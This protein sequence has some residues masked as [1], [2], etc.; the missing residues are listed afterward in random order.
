MKK[1]K[2]G[3][4]LIDAGAITALQLNEVLEDQKR[5]GGK[6]GTILLERRYITEK[7][8]F[9]ALSSQLNVP[10]VDFSKSTIPEAVTKIVPQDLAEK[11]SVFPVAVKRTAQG[12]VLVL[13]MADPTD[14]NVQD[15]IRFTTGY[16]VEPV[17]ALET[18]IQYVIRD[19]YYHQNGKGSYRMEADMDL[20]AGASDGNKEIY[21]IER[22]QV[23]EPDE[24]TA[25]IGPSDREEGAEGPD[26]PNLT[27]ELKALLKLL[28]KK[29]IITPKEFLDEFNENS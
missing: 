28:A 26:K 5:Y 14:V 15:E 8:Y 21:Q 24:P 29:G 23:S 18:T 16:K 20:G 4:I 10:A 6:I 27:R 1:K 9:R 17:L 12:N 7:E 13:A 19:F 11:H 22:L 2:L 3:E 25:L